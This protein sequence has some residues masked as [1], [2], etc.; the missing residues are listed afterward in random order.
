MLPEDQLAPPPRT[1]LPRLNIGFCDFIVPTT[2]AEELLAQLQTPSTLCPCF[3]QE[4]GAQCQPPSRGGPRQ[5]HRPVQAPN[6]WLWSG[7]KLRAGLTLP[8]APPCTMF[9]PRPCPMLPY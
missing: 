3:P 6:A 2:D 4:Y 9:R 7:G 5:Y 1:L 8:H